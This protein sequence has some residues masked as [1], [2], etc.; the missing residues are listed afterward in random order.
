MGDGGGSN[1]EVAGGLLSLFHG[2]QP[3]GAE[4]AVWVCGEAARGGRCEE[5]VEMVENVLEGRR[6]RQGGGKQRLRESPCIVNGRIT[7]WLRFHLVH[8]LINDRRKIIL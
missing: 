5:Q 1:W 7:I 3:A 8:W 2:K 6:G 4:A